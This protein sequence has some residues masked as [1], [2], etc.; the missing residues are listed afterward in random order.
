MNQNN[1]TDELFDDFLA[2]THTLLPKGKYVDWD[3]LVVDNIELFHKALDHL[4]TQRVREAKI[5]ELE[6]LPIAKLD[7]PNEHKSQKYRDAGKF[8]STVYVPKRLESLRKVVQ[9]VHTT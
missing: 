4:I 3:V 8:I 2:K 7:S 1:E 5:E 9:D 6:L